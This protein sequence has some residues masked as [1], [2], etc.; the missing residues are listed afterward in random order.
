[1]NQ[2]SASTAKPVI[3]PKPAARLKTWRGWDKMAEFAESPVAALAAIVFALIALA[4]IFAPLITPQDPYDLAGLSILDSKLAPGESSFS[5]MTHWLGTDGLGRDMYSAIIYGLRISLMVGVVSSLFALL[6]GATVGLIA[7]YVGGRTDSIL[8]RLVDLQMSFP[9]ILIALVLLAILGR[10]F[11]KTMI[12]LIAVQWS[13]YARTVRASA[14]V[15]RERE[16][17][18]AA[19]S[20]RLGHMR[21]LFRHLLPNCAAPLIVVVTVQFA[22]AITL[23]ATLSFLGVGLPETEPSLGLLIS[24]GYQYMLSGAYWISIYPGIALLTVIIA[25]NLVGDRFRELFNPGARR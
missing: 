15:E 11:D 21:I 17:I 8:M 25:I 4:A 23:E 22:H 13:Y 6:I 14:L 5:G 1:M 16:Y 12:A 20:L 2:D 18:E 3:A 7:A 10:G 24:N 9:A 19:R